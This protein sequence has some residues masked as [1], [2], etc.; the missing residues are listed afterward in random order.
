VKRVQPTYEKFKRFAKEQEA[1]RKDVERALGVL[2]QVGLLFGTL[3]E[4][5]PWRGCV[6]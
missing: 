5:G 4:L 2:Q 6:M 1:A 3:L